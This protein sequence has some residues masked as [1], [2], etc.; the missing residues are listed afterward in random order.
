VPPAGDGLEP[1]G[2]GVRL[3]DRLHDG[4]S[5]PRSAARSRDVTTREAIERALG[6][7][8]VQARALVLH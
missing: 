2:A 4:K 6:D 3:G 1:G 7:R 8:R 5:E